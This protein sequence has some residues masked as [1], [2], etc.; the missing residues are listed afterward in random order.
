MAIVKV[1]EVLASSEKS[2]D[3]A[4]QQAVNYASESVKGIKSVYI[5]EMK[6]EVSNNKIVSYGINAK[7]SF[8]V[9]R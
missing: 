1:I 3:D 8:E 2:F 6:A 4:A 5:K 9:N 7:I